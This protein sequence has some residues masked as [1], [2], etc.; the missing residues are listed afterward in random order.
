MSAIV[1]VRPD[2]EPVR[3]ELSGQMPLCGQV[4]NEAG[5]PVP[6]AKV[7]FNDFINPGLC[8]EWADETGTD[9]R[10]E[11]TEAPTNEV[12][13]SIT[14]TGTRRASPG[15]AARPMKRREAARREQ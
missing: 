9:G 10:F 1:S 3:L 15:C 6:F 4:V 5:L 13:L 14:A 2:M 11:W 7:S 12:A 8:F